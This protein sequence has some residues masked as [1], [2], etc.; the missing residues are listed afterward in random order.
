VKRF[1]YDSYNQLRQH[2]ADF[3]AAYN[4]AR[5]LRTLRGLT[6]YEAIC[7]IRT[8][9]PFRVTHDPHHQTPGPNI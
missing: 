1:H 4:F 7:K 2:L 9:D 8:D 3:V 5:R 6:S